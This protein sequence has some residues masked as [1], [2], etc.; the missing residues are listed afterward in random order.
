[1]NGRLFFET[2]ESYLQ[3]ISNT[4]D[5]DIEKVVDDIRGFK[6]LRAFNIEKKRSQTDNFKT[7]DD[8]EELLDDTM[9][10]IVWDPYFENILNEEREFQISDQI[11]RITEFGTFFYEGDQLKGRMNDIQANLVLE[12]RANARSSRFSCADGPVLIEPD[13]YYLPGADCDGYG[14]YYGGS[15][16]SNTTPPPPQNGPCGLST[17]SKTRTGS[18][19]NI[20]GVN[21]TSDLLLTG[22]SDRRIKAR[23]WSQN[24]GI[25][26][27]AGTSTRS[28]NRA[29]RIWW[30]ESA[31]RIYLKYEG[32]IQQK[33]PFNNLITFDLVP[34]IED[35]TNRSRLGKTF[36][37]TSAIVGT[38]CDPITGECKEKFKPASPFKIKKLETCHYVL[39]EGRH[40]EISLKYQ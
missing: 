39:D 31:N 17:N 22:A 20:F 24:Y 15:G 19:S 12:S 33:D 25:F 16:T 4:I 27:S 23:F 32:Q 13:I 30:A 29:L 26:S 8:F 14:G 3:F 6:S 2:P 28:Q 5:A 35:R 21:H 10:D 38:A 37:W 36:Q 9:D 40:G 7:A 34:T 18:S 11:Y 1:M